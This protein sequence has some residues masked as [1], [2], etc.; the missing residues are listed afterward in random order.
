[1]KTRI[2]LAIVLLATIVACQKEAR[3]PNEPLNE[4]TKNYP[5]RPDFKP[6]ESSELPKLKSAQIVEDMTTLL[7]TDLV[8]ALIGTGP[9]APVINSVTFT[10]AET[11]AG[12]FTDVTDVFGFESGIV[13]SSGNAHFIEGP[14]SSDNATANNGLPGDPDLDALIPG[15]SSHD[16]TVLEFEFEC[17]NI[18]YI[19]FQYVFASEEYN[20]YV[21]TSFN[22]V[23]GFFVNGVNI[24]LIP[25][26][27]TPVS[28]NNLNCGNPYDAPAGG[29]YCE[30]FN[31]NDLSDGGGT[32]DTEADGFT[33]V[34]TAETAV[35]PGVNTIKLAVAD[36]GDWILDS[37]V[38]IKG[39][40]FVCAPPYIDVSIDIK[41]GSDPNSINCLN[42][43]EV[44][45]VAI[46][47]TPDFDATMV[48][49]TTVVFQGASECH[50]D[51]KTG[52]AKRHE[53]DVDMDGDIDLVFHFFL[54]ETDLDCSATE[55]MLT[56]ETFDGTP[57]SG[58][59]A[60]NMV[61]IPD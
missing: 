18:Q 36:A 17:E 37:H 60:I 12:I 50:V 15:Y 35:D 1:M 43:K 8:Y 9:N 52:I 2:F 54:S 3:M 6:G 21:N 33:M 58:S 41:P 16:A 39:E 46:L 57:I 31:N 25:G 32:F 11:S 19:S 49:H 55:G 45:P 22:D 20:E 51:K 4:N 53:E 28:I 27:S 5:E 13:L 24:A 56:G 42:E 40:S 61:N 10:G 59:D 30:L 47:S 48:D 26:T 38:L 14:N 44:I 29:S 34:L 23:F 7:A